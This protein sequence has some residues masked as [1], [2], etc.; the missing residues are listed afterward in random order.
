MTAREV[1]VNLRDSLEEN[2]NR[3][4]CNAPDGLRLNQSDSRVWSPTN[5]TT[6]QQGENRKLQRK[7]RFRNRTSTF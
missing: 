3:S 2:E 6:S 1:W 7:E 5:W 4:K